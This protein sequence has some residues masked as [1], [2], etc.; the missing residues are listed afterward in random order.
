MQYAEYEH[1]PEY[2]IKYAEYAIKYVK[3]YAEYAKKNM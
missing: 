3:R 2:A 1:T